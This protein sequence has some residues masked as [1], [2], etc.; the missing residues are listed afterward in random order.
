MS[1][2]GHI[3]PNGELNRMTTEYQVYGTSDGKLVHAGVHR[4]RRM[5]HAVAYRIQRGW[6]R[7]AMRQHGK[8]PHVDTLVVHPVGARSVGVSGPADRYRIR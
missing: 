7:W 8:V 4:K 1:Y 2:T 3:W 5:T 6:E